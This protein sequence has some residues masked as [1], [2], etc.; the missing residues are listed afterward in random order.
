MNKHQILKGSL[1]L[2][3]ASLG[4][5]TAMASPWKFGVISDTQWADCA[6][7][8][9]SPL[10]CPAS[11]IKQIDTEFI[12]KGVS[13]VISVGDVVDSSSSYSLQIRSLYAQD[14]YN[15]GI[16]FY[17][18]RGNH[19]VAPNPAVFAS[20]FPQ[21]A[22]GGVNNS[23]TTS[24]TTFLSGYYTA[25]SGT[26]VDSTGSKNSSSD[27]YSVLSTILNS[28]V[29]V[30]TAS[31][32][33]FQSGS[34]FSYP[35]S[36]CTAASGTSAGSLVYN[37][38]APTSG[39]S[40]SG[41]LSGTGGVSYSFDFN[42]ARFVMLDQFYGSD[43]NNS[44]IPAQ[45]GWIANRVEVGGTSGR[46]LQAFVFSHKNILGGNHKDG[47]FG[48]SLS[49]DPG[50]GSVYSGTA[51]TFR[52]EAEDHFIKTLD[53]ND[54]AYAI[55]GHDHHHKYSVVN[56]PQNSSYSVRQLILASD[57][58]K[59]YTPANPM[60]VNE[61]VVSEELYQVGYYI[62]TVDGPRV[63]MD[64]YGIPANVEGKY[65]GTANGY[66]TATPTLTGNWV[67]HQTIGHSLNGQE[68]LIA[69]GS[70]YTTVADN[71]DLAVSGSAT[72]G[73]TGFVGT[74]MEILSGSN[75][76]TVTTT[77][78]SGATR[79]LTKAIATGWAP[80]ISGTTAS[81]VLSLWGFADISAT[82]TDT[83]TVAIT[84]PTTALTSTISADN[85]VL[86]A[87]DPKSGKWINAVD[88]NITGGTKTAING[89]YTSSYTLGYHG[90]VDNGDGTAT[91]WAVV[92]GNA[93]DFAVIAKPTGHY[94]PWDL[95]SDGSVNAS[96]YAAILAKIRA[97]TTD[98]AY[99]LNNDGRVDAAD[100]RW[101]LQH[102]STNY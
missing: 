52:K 5:S 18:L 36:N 70:S 35:T 46:P 85:Y 10:T 81:D 102:Y 13:V 44:C 64:Y 80:A 40:Y 21:I 53:S 9:K 65:V 91:V 42:N 95:N 97:K 99:D 72:Y 15:A 67:K 61:T 49:N 89:A 3:L 41:S 79:A 37:F 16:G 96:D 86:G 6:N 23:G 78:K 39:S 8:G 12:N 48:A 19:D 45:L 4:V 31:S 76:S 28:T 60:S 47:L 32:S 26:G 51:A 75:T 87:R 77:V 83:I 84:V 90:I 33:T 88:Y 14:L 27:T 24:V 54:V 22:N 62:F 58:S 38:T 56:D 94:L 43:S 93:Q 92:N 20:T 25:Y 101:L 2:L 55:G 57:S 30:P 100:A 98:T 63:T 82:K 7:D 59:F 73:E 66:F 69:Q 50:D 11:I 29:A 1:A 71:T 34:N 17:P 68:F 74:S